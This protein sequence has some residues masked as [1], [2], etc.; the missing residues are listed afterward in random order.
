[1]KRMGF[2]DV[3]RDPMGYGVENLPKLLVYA[4]IVGKAPYEG[5]TFRSATALGIKVIGGLR[6]EILPGLEAKWER[7]MRQCW[8]NDSKARPSFEDVCRLLGSREF[9]GNLDSSEASRFIEYQRRVCPSDLIR[10]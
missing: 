3:K 6:L 7:V 10:E 1:M 5:L 4:T 2:G 9:I 8:D